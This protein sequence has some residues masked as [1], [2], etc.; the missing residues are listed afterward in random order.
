MPI[1]VENVVIAPVFG[2]VPLHVGILVGR[3][4]EVQIGAEGRHVIKGFGGAGQARRVEIFSDLHAGQ[5]AV[6]GKQS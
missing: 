6:V 1:Q 4:D 3:A 2:A 5:G